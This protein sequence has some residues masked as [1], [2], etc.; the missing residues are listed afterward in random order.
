MP[1]YAT[2]GELKEALDKVT[3]GDDTI[4]QLAL[5]GATA[6]ITGQTRR[7]FDQVTEARTLDGNGERRLVVPDLVSVTALTLAPATAGT[8]VAL[9]VSDY[10]LGPTSDGSGRPY[11][12]IDL[13]IVGAYA[14]WYQGQR[15][16]SITGVWG[17]PAVPADIRMVCISL[18][19]RFWKSSQA[20]F[21]DTIGMDGDG[22]PVFSK[23]MTSWDRQVL[24]SYRRLSIV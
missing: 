14:G 6:F 21:S 4:L 9:A 11:R 22:S 18:A 17:W 15:T 2:I 13:S 12:W 23:Q 1:S 5:D 3:S 7:R 24:K 19:A 8:P 10:Y 20:G 16:V